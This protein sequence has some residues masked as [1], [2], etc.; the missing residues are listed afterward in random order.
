MV[1]L[2]SPTSIRKCIQ[3]HDVTLIKPLFLRYWAKENKKITK[4]GSKFS[5]T[6]VKQHIATDV[7]AVL[8]TVAVV[9]L[10]PIGSYKRWP[11]HA[12]KN[13]NFLAP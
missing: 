4:Q 6:H 7:L 5:H 12:V 10:A 13:I 9:S 11:V 8:I 1:L 2:T 3:A